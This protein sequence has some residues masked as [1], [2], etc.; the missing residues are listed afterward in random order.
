[1]THVAGPNHAEGVAVIGAFEF[2]WD[3]DL[4][5]FVM[6]ADCAAIVTAI[7]STN[8]DSSSI[9]AFIRPAKSS[10]ENPRC[11][12]ISYVPRRFNTPTDLLATFSYTIQE[13]RFYIEEALSHVLLAYRADIFLH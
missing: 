1:M 11:L 9:A 5:T 12:G 2:P 8:L 13:P 7:N 3:L 6:E 10:C 4:Q